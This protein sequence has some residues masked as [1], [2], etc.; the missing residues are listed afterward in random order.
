MED[1]LAAKAVMQQSLFSDSGSAPADIA[2]PRA[3][4]LHWRNVVL[5]ALALAGVAFITA[6]VAIA[7][8]L[9][10]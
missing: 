6:C 1:V 9:M 5:M 3:V 2:N 10:H 7:V 4:E 8:A